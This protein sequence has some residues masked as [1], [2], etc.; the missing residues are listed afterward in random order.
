M[1]LDLKNVVPAKRP[2][3][4][5]QDT[6]PKKQRHVSRELLTFL[7]FV[8]LSA[9]FWFAQSLQRRYTV[10]VQI[11][12]T[13]DSIPPEVGLRSS[14]PRAVEVSVEDEG[15]H[16]LEYQLRGIAPIYLH[17]QRGKQLIAGF[18]LSAAELSSEVRRRLYTTARV[19][20]ITPTEIDATAY[21][22]ES[23]VVPVAL[24]KLPSLAK[25]YA[26]GEIELTPAEVT[27]YGSKESLALLKSVT[28]EGLEEQNLSSTT[29]TKA[30]LK[31]P[32][33]MYASTSVIQVHIPVEQLTEHSFTLP[34]DVTG[35]PDGFVLMP[36]PSVATIQVTLPRSRYNELKA[37]DL[38]L[39]VAYPEFVTNA[40]DVTSEPKQLP[41]QLVKK[42]NWLKH[43]RI[44]PDRVQYVIEARK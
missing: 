17:L 3:S 33:G 21:R 44:S 36:L 26:V 6:S 5:T 31:L 19:Q 13:Y 10:L 27:V 25:G 38:S 41:I 24:G 14:L 40:G 4:F 30:R 15:A 9:S 18:S 37:E 11:P 35:M 23:K 34:V 7:F 2:S 43:Y 32:Q 12:L 28:T 42:P 29:T 16:L 22:R 39:A 20:A 1:R 8:L